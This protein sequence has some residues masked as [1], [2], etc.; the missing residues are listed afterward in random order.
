METVFSRRPLGV[1]IAILGGVGIVFWGCIGSRHCRRG[2]SVNWI[3]TVSEGTKV[4]VTAQIGEGA[5]VGMPSVIG[6]DVHIGPE[7][8]WPIVSKFEDKLRFSYP[9]S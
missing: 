1:A 7:G 9:L 4:W 5:S 3:S 8:W 6:R 2:V